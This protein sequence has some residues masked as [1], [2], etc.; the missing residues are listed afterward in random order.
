MAM[1][2][3]NA[4]PTT[5]RMRIKMSFT[6][7]T[8]PSSPWN[9]IISSMGGIMRVKKDPPVAPIK[10]MNKP[11]KGTT[12]AKVPEKIKI[13]VSCQKTRFSLHV[14]NTSDD[15]YRAATTIPCLKGPY[16]L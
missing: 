16:F 2:V 1:T 9:A 11:R 4:E 10:D 15:L 13:L 5:P 6:M 7:I 12:F 8:M 3:P 14:V